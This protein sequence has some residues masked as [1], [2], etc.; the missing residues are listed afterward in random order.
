MKRDAFHALA[1]SMMVAMGAP[2]AAQTPTPMPTPV[3]HPSPPQPP[4]VQGSEAISKPT[5][6]QEKICAPVLIRAGP[7]QGQIISKCR[8]TDREKRQTSG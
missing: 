7:N 3:V 8:H 4:E 5:A 1:I 2:L 6:T